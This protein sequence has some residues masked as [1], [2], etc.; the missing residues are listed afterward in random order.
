MSAAAVQPVPVPTATIV[1]GIRC[2]ECGGE[3]SIPT[4][5]NR[6]RIRRCPVCRGEGELAS[7]ALTLEQVRALAA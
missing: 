4:G 2:D 3:G 7:A 6:S 1:I 5:S